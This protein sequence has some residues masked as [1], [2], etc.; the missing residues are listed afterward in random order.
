MMSFAANL[1]RARSHL[2]IVFGL[3]SASALIMSIETTKTGRVATSAKG[4]GT[5]PTSAETRAATW[6]WTNLPPSQRTPEMRN[7]AARLGVRDATS[8]RL[9]SAE[10]AAI[11]L[12]LD[13]SHGEPR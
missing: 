8:V 10:A 9:G 4:G 12:A 3:I 5:A 11:L 7:A 1:A 13:K 2:I 6:A